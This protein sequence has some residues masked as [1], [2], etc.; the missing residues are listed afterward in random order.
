MKEYS[1]Q[2]LKLILKIT[3]SV[4]SD[5]REDLDSLKDRFRND[6]M[7]ET[8]LSSFGTETLLSEWRCVLR[9]KM[10]TQKLIDE[11]ELKK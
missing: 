4:V 10:I 6:D 1:M 9:L 2:D 7:E 5:L 8:G 11:M 3:D